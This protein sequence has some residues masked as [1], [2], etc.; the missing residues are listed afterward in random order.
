MQVSN[1]SFN[2]AVFIGGAF[3]FTSIICGSESF[4][5]FESEC[6]AQPEDLVSSRPRQQRGRRNLRSSTTNTP[7]DG[8]GEEYVSLGNQ[9]LPPPTQRESE[10]DSSRE[11]EELYDVIRRLEEE[12]NELQSKL[13]S[14]GSDA[15]KSRN[16]SASA[17][18]AQCAQLTGAMKELKALL[19]TAKS[20][21][22][23]TRDQVRSL[24]GELASVKASTMQGEDRAVS[25]VKKQLLAVQR[26]LEEKNGEFDSNMNELNAVVEGLEGERD[27]LQQQVKRLEMEKNDLQLSA[28]AT[29][30]AGKQK[31]EELSTL[32]KNL[33]QANEEV[34]IL[35]LQLQEKGKEQQKLERKMAEVEVLKDTIAGLQKEAREAE[36]QLTDCEC[37]ELRIKLEVEVK[38][39]VAMAAERD[40]KVA[41]MVDVEADRDALRKE[42]NVVRFNCVFFGTFSIPDPLPIKCC[43]HKRQNNDFLNA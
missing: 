6:G 23:R 32:Q 26:E 27:A 15:N 37:K 12:R 34:S 24:E 5:D 43:R 31:T 28:A 13:L 9:S 7:D 39:V 29:T 33:L 3:L 25:E 18:C 30:T 4:D 8:K 42:L 11:V 38:K 16:N 40:E 1:T 21:I 19:E 17:P 20:E 36:K 35:K 14:L 22:S 41:A 2:A 10:N